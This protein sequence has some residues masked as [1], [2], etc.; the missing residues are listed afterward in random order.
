MIKSLDRTGIWRTYSIDSG[1]PGQRIEHIAEDSEGYLWFATWDNGVS[2]FDGDAFQNFTKQNGLVNDH[3]YFISKDSQKRLWFGTLNGVCWYDGAEFRHLEDTG[4]AGRPVQFIYEDS[5][6]RIWCGGHRTLGYYDGTV[7]RDMIPLYLQQYQEPPSP[8]WPNQCRGIAQDP[9]GHL[10]FGFN[11]L[12]RFDGQSFHRYEEKEG[13]PRGKINYAVGQ[14]HTGTVWV[15]QHESKN[16]LS[17]YTD[18]TFEPVEINLGSPLRKIQSDREGRMWFSTSEGVLYQDGDGFS[19]FTPDDGLPHPAVKAVLQDRDHQ[20]WFATWGGVGL[21]DAHSISVFDFSSRGSKRVNEISQIAQDRRGDMWVGYVA[22]ALNRLEKSVFRFDGEDFDFVGTE[23]GFDIDNCFAIYEDC[24]GN[25]WF[26]GHNG[27]FR[28]NG[29]KIKKMQTIAGLGKRS[30]S[31]ITQDSQGRF[32]FGHWERNNIIEKKDLLVSPLKIIYQRGEAFQTIFVE[33]KNKDPFSYIGTVIAGRNGEVYF[34]LIHQNFSD[35]AKGF[36]RWHPE[37]GLKFYGIEDGLIDHRV[38]NLLKDRDGNL[39][40]ATQRGLSCFDGSTFHNFTPKDGLP[41]NAIRCL[42]EDSQGHLWLGTDGGVVHYDG[43]L[44]QTIKS[45][46]I[47]PVLKILEDRYGSFWFGTAQN[48]LVRYRQRQTSPRVRLLQVVADK[49]YENPKEVIASTTDQQVTFEYKGMS[50]STHPS[51]MLYVY[52][53]EGYDADWQPATRKMRSYYRN[54]SP[55]EYTFQVKAIDRDLN[56]SEIAQVQLSVE[57][58]PRIEGLTATLNNQGANE[59]IGQSEVLQ[60]FQ[61]RLRKIAPTDL[62]VLIIG[63]TG[64]GKGLAARVLHAQSHYCNG[65]FIQVNCGALSETLIDSELFGHEKGAFTSAES[66]RLGKVELAKGGTLFLDEVSDMAVGTQARMLRL[67]EEGT[68][69]RVGGSE[70]LK[71]QARIVAATNRNLEDMVSAGVFREDLY[72]R[73]QVFPILLPPLRE[74]KE[75]IPHLAEFFKNRMATHLGK[76]VAPLTPEVIEVLQTCDWP[77][78]V[79]ELEHTIQRAVIVCRGSQIEVR[80]LGL[81]GSRIEGTVLEPK[82]RTVTVSQ[83]REVVPLD[84]YERHYIL[85]VLKIT[86]YQISGNRGTAALLGLPPSTL[87]GKMRKLGIKIP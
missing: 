55:G 67:L 65:P 10:W 16:E 43:Q 76:D 57:P 38:N 87:Y 46:H 3:V 1:L 41:S 26:G 13:F 33:D 40:I 37:E 27:L 59:F 75:D 83:D 58:D 56:Y 78:N 74:R 62:S 23:D 8:E 9:E 30:V 31:A 44:F 21:Y 85:E 18:G 15:G 48:T 70:T 20:F 60:Q 51:D 7:F 80:D 28:Y 19:R 50:F 17:C 69:E 63:E 66:R 2:R 52:R 39:W 36:A 54:L 64:V 49:V 24:D 14:D 71:I 25:L 45:S 11:Y 61:F 32:I 12:I 82:R 79:R 73:F 72:Y 77:G 47:G 84:E 68:F 5:E 6:G 29:K 86:N 35:N 22:P 42:F 4:I 34:H 81:H 53:L